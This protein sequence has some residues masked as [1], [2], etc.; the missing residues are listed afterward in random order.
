MFAYDTNA[1][2]NDSYTVHPVDCLLN[3]QLSDDHSQVV[4]MQNIQLQK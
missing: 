2:L 4:I 3:T 1:L